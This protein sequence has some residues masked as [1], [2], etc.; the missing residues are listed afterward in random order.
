ML[1]IDENAVGSNI[2]SVNDHPT[3]VDTYYTLIL[4]HN[5]PQENPFMIYMYKNKRKSYIE[6][7]YSGIWRL[8]N[9]T[10][11]YILDFD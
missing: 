6:I 7:P 10:Y 9:E 11:E 8:Y 5:T 2:K 4:T 3:N 1:L